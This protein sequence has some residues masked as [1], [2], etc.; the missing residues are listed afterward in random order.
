MLFI[1]GI[2]IWFVFFFST[3][4]FQNA[5]AFGIISYWNQERFRWIR[6]IHVSFKIQYVTVYP[7]TEISALLYH[8][9]NTFLIHCFDGIYDISYKEIHSI[10]VPSFVSIRTA[11]PFNI[12]LSGRYSRLIPLNIELFECCFDTVSTIYALRSVYGWM[13]HSIKSH[14]SKS[15]TSS[16]ACIYV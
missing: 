11:T 9:C 2:L 16:C 12:P 1:S 6:V 10:F 15:H 3:N 14:H 7:V 5:S 8:R 4:V 13:R